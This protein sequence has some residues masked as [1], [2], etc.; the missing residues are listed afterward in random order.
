MATLPFRGKI[1]S[2]EDGEKGQIETS[3][4]PACNDAPGEAEQSKA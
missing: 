3:S 2:W 1:F 4:M